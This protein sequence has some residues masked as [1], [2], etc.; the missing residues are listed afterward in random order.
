MI[1]YECI[2]SKLKTP[3]RR[4]GV[5]KLS[6]L[7]EPEGALNWSL[8]R[9][10]IVYTPTLPYSYTPKKLVTYHLSLRQSPKPL[11]AGT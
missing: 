11:M 2:L 4:D 1:A 7:G 6:S 3:S 5:K 10:G 8:K 9:Q